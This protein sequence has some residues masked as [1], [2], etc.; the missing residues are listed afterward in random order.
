MTTI[1]ET[2]TK[3]IKKRP[4]MTT[5]PLHSYQSMIQRIKSSQFGNFSPKKKKTQQ[6]KE[7]I[8]T[9]HNHQS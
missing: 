8:R 1:I 4:R 3:T 7:I 2:I 9:L 5:Y 6:Q